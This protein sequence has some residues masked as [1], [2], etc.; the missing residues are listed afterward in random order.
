MTFVTIRDWWSRLAAQHVAAASLLA[1]ARPRRWVIGY[2]EICAFLGALMLVTEVVATSEGPAASI[3]DALFV[4]TYYFV[5]PLA[6]LL[7]AFAVAAAIAVLLTGVIQ[8]PRRPLRALAEA[9][10]ACTSF[11]LLL[12]VARWSLE[13]RAW[14]LEAVTT[15][16]TPAATAHLADPQRHPLPSLGVRG[17]TELR[18]I[19]YDDGHSE[20]HAECSRGIGRWDQLFLRADGQYENPTRIHRLGAWAYLW[21]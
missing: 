6:H 11:A 4:S 10:C 20:L 1:R 9:A 13:L 12:G 2:V 8:R 19:E 15:R 7:R 5:P 14:R 16:L 18:R 17:C 3:P 21:D